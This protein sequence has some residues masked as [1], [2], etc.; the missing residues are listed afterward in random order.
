L[1]D[2]LNRI[3]YRQ[4]RFLVE[5]NGEAIATL[6]PVATRPG[7]T[8]TDLVRLLGRLGVPDEGLADDLEAIQAQQPPAESILAA[9]PVLSFDLRVA[10]VHAGLA[11]QLAAAGQPIGAHDLLIGATALA[12]NAAVFTANLRDFRRIPGLVV[13][14]LAR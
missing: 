1:S 7:M 11:T 2:V 8:V 12:H 3:R 13:Q 9:V 10:R 5:R 14:Q 4:E 6:E